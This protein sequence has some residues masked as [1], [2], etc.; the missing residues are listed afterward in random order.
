MRCPLC[1]RPTTWRDNPHRPFCSQRCRLAD[2]EG[3]LTGRYVVPGSP[4]EGG[5]LAELDERG[6]EAMRPPSGEKT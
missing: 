4:E 6:D 1:G 3:W 5:A 2:L